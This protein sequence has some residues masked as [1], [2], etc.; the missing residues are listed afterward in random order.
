MERGAPRAEDR[1]GDSR[2]RGKSAEREKSAERLAPRAERGEGK[3]AE[4]GAPSAEDRKRESRERGKSAELG[5]PSAETGDID[6]RTFSSF[7]NLFL[8][9]LYSELCATCLALF[10]GTQRSELGAR[11]RER[12]CFR[13]PLSILAIS[14]ASDLTFETSSAFRYSRRNA[15]SRWDTSSNNE[16]LEILRK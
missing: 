8:G 1:K 14:V 11:S 3:S 9:A 6:G 5:A 12:I 13:S 16:P 15:T 10:L 4:R 7:W 2:E